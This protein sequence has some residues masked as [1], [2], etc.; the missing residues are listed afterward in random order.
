MN[1]TY[2]RISGERL[3]KNIKVRNVFFFSEDAGRRTL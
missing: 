2:T 1:Y 3:K